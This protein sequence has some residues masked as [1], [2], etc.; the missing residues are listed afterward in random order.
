M[1]IFIKKV[2]IVSP[3]AGEL[4]LLTEVNDEVFSKKILGDGFAITPKNNVFCSPIDGKITTA[5]PTGHIYSIKHKT[6]FEILIHIGINTVE[7]K[8]NG[9]SKISNE[10]DKVKKG[11]SL[12]KVNFD[13]ISNLIKSID[14]PIVFIA[15]TMIN[16]KLTLIKTGKVKKGEV[17]AIVEKSKK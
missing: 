5:F 12:V 11:D 14:T 10:E 7:L 1:L 17:I 16:K 4:K 13:M 9:F 6:G 15:E 2:E 3:I 8:G